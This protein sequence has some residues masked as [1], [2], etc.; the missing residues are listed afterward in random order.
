[1]AVVRDVLDAIER[2]APRRYA[3]S[4][5]KI[6]LQVGDPSDEVRTVAVSLDRSLAAVEYAGSI[7]AQM[8]VSHHPLIFSPLATVDTG[9]LEGRTVLALARHGISFAAAHTNWDAAT[10]GVNDT[11]AALLGLTNVVPFGEASEVRSLKLVF[12]CPAKDADRVLDAVSAAG[13]GVIGA[14]SRCAYMSHGQG[15]FIGDD[16]THPSVGEKGRR[17]IVDEVRVE[18]VLPAEKRHLIRKALLESHPYEEPACDWVM[19]AS[20]EE[21]PLGRVG[22]LPRPMP[23]QAFV[24]HVDHRL[25]TRSLAWGSAD[26]P[27]SRVAAVGGSADGEWRHAAEAGADVLVTGEVK[28]HIAVEAVESGFAILSSGHYATEHPGA[29]SLANAL[30]KELP[31]IDFHVFEPAPGTAGRPL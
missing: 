11:L 8:L 21:M 2:L 28:Q 9:S 16:T 29:A 20:A 5:D 17:E 1:M 24:D 3:L 19:L 10:G 25:A 30:Q 23:L 31:E 27:I 7:G 14:Y 4:N 22:D 26:R 13:A 6:G 18:T 15:T 12:F